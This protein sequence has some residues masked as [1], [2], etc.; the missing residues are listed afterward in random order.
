[1]KP[2]GLTL[3][4]ALISMV[5]LSVAFSA[6][7]ALIVGNLRENAKAGARTQATQLLGYLGRQVAGGDT[8]AILPDNSTTPSA[9]GY[10]QLQAAFSDLTRERQ[11]ADVGLYRA[12]IENRGGY[13]AGISGV[14]LVQYRIS[15]CWRTPEGE[16]CLRAD[17]LGRRKVLVNPAPP[18]VAN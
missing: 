7:T 9:W 1:M 5:V 4:E 17:T 10:G 3:I 6:F 2:R 13:T 11:Y 18:A 15:V 16:S 12:S 8:P 14:D